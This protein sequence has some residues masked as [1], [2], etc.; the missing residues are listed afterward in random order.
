MYNPQEQRE[1]NGCMESLVYTR[2]VFSLLLVPFALILGVVMM[3]LVTFV[4]LSIHPLLALL[5]LVSSLA[6]IVAL[7]RWEV[8]RIAKEMPPE[9]H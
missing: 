4:A 3:V 8:R 7:A 1:P 6:A 9:D 5:V 2:I